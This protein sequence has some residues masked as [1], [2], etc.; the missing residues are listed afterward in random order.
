LPR[1]H[2]WGWGEEGGPR[3]VGRQMDAAA[4][5]RGGLEVGAPVASG[6]A[7]RQHRGC[8][9]TQAVTVLGAPG[10]FF[11]AGGGWAQG[12]RVAGAG[13]GGTRGAG[14]VS[15]GKGFKCRMDGSGMKDRS[16]DSATKRAAER[17][18]GSGAAGWRG[19]P[20]HGGRGGPREPRGPRTIVRRQ[21]RQQVCAARH[22]GG[23]PK[24]PPAA[25]Q[26][27]LGRVVVRGLLE[28]V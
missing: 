27:A 28:S 3:Q 6:S 26:E 20:I 10:L 16:G 22:A 25:R 7:V 18:E 4:T 1:R 24:R 15:L 14:I 8:R 9:R 17:E 2:G 11:L 13:D 5:R 21:W 19:G 23:A 12:S